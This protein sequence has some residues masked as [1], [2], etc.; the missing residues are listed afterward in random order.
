MKPDIKKLLAAVLYIIAGGII[1]YL[2][3]L[4]QK[5]GYYYQKNKP[6]QYDNLIAP[7]DFP[8]YK[9]EEEIK[10]EKDSLKA[11]FFPYVEKKDKIKSQVI[12][13]INTIANNYFS[14]KN[15]EKSKQFLIDFYEFAYQLIDSIYNEGIISYHDKKKLA[16]DTVMIIS[17]AY[18]QKVPVSKFFT[19][20]KAASLCKNKIKAFVES[21]PLENKL[22]F[23]DE[24]NCNKLLKPNIYYREDLTKKELE[25]LL[26]T[27]SYTNGM[28]QKG[29]LIIATGELV[30]AKK[31]KILNSLK[32]EYETKVTARHLNRVLGG[33]AILI[34]LAL[35]INFLFIEF[36]FGKESFI[37]HVLSVS[38][39]LFFAVLTFFVIKYRYINIYIIPFALI[40]IIFRAFY[41]ENIAISITI[42][43]IF[44][45]SFLAPH[46]YEFLI[47]NLSA[48]IIAVFS[49]RTFT[50][51]SHFIK[52]AF[53]A[54]ITYS[55]IYLA[56]TLIQGN[57]VESL[58]LSTFI[59]FGLSSI[60]L[61]LSYGLIYIIEKTFG[62]LSDISLIE[63]SNTNKPLLKR[64]SEEAP[65]TFQHSIQVANLA[66][67]VATKI[68]ANALLVKTGALYHD[69]GKLY[70]PEF[71]T[72]N[73]FGNFNPHENLAPEES[74]QIIIGH[75]T[76]G[77]ELAKKNKLP[78]QIID[79]IT[80]HHGTSKVE[81]FLHKF[82]KMNPDK[83]PDESIFTYPG[84]KP[85]SKETAILMMCDAVEAASRSLPDYK[86]ET[87]SSLV[88]KIIDT[89]FK[90]KQFD[91][92][93]LTLQDIST[94]KSVL[95]IKLQNIY[96]TRVKYPE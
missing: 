22:H 77:V 37:T 82:K 51:R 10:A 4:Q 65:G 31:Y 66:Y 64:L 50:A 62:L 91:N 38:V 84:P 42:P 78:A 49:M 68:K 29:E 36:E 74:A 46:S 39:L 15:N 11:T 87:I 55:F 40:P 34:L 44:I 24:F 63:L 58:K 72:E 94:A 89:Q 43:S 14:D 26:A 23:E 21:H 93:T 41:S 8:V 59:I 6:W 48:G 35:I 12:E 96:H 86:A 1:L 33:Y 7:F 16:S 18:M 53:F 2:F 85:F 5:F 80:T 19:V 90:N 13:N 60:F 45:L 75:V 54:F 76:K 28:I 9:T 67:D 27:V 56:F 95:K 88:D 3:P 92:S 61:L 69:I 81:Y 57:P 17:G 25:N 32:K 73:Q 20:K 79:F 47:Y 52:T 71:F 30:N 70:N 83:T